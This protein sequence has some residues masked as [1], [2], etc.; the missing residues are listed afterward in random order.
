LVAQG[1]VDLSTNQ[2]LH[3]HGP[4]FYFVLWHIDSPQEMAGPASCLAS[5][6]VGEVQITFSCHSHVM[7]ICTWPDHAKYV[8]VHVRKA[9]PASILHI[10]ARL[11]GQNDDQVDGLT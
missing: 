6:Q 5:H 1:Q 3:L 4:C 2:Q 9:C 10:P 11:S 8:G 7:F